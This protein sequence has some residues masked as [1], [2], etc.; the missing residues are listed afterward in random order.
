MNKFQAVYFYEPFTP[1]LN[2]DN[3]Y[4]ENL[5]IKL[6]V[7]TLAK[8]LRPNQLIFYQEAGRIRQYLEANPKFEMLTHHR[9]IQVWELKDK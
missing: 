5:K 8:V 4:K 9:G 2:V 6:F 7:D 3:E 1:T